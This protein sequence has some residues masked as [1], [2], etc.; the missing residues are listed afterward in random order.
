MK[1]EGR[2]KEVSKL[3]QTNNKAMYIV[4]M[5]IGLSFKFTCTVEER[6]GGRERWV[7]DTIRQVI[8]SGAVVYS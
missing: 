5:F 4:C 7:H 3:G 2:R 6:D 1:K 8:C